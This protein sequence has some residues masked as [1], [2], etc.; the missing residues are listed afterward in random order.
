M[1]IAGDSPYRSAPPTILAENFRC[2]LPGS[3]IIEDGKDCRSTPGHHRVTGTEIE[4]LLP[5]GGNPWMLCENRELEIV[6]HPVCLLA[7]LLAQFLAQLLA[8]FLVKKQGRC[9]SAAAR[10][11]NDSMCDRHW[12]TGPNR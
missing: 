8:Q 12:P 11:T 4:Q 2:L 10:L 6:P 7:C 1:I 9:R 5:D 3:I